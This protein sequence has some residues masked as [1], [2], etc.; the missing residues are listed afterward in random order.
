MENCEDT[1]LRNNAISGLVFANK[2][3]NRID[4]AKKYALM[5]PE[6]PE[7]SRE[8]L[9]AVCLKGEELADEMQQIYMEFS[10]WLGSWEM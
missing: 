8:T 6:A 4:E 3:L 1:E 9:L 10:N 5:Y 2:S 7:T